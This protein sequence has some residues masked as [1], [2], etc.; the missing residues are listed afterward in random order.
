MPKSENVLL[1]PRYQPT[2]YF[3]WCIHFHTQQFASLRRYPAAA[4]YA[5]NMAAVIV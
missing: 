4:H 2:V 3:D 5:S 1:T